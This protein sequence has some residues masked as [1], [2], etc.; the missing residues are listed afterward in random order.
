MRFSV[1]A[2]AMVA[3]VVGFGSTLAIV[4]EAAARLGATPAQTVSWVTVLCLGMAWTSAYLSTRYRMPIVTAWSLA[5]AVLIAAAPAGITM[6]DA[7]GAFI[8]SAVLTLLS[9][10]VPA[11]GSAIARLP[12]AVAGAMLAGLL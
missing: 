11:R 7:I 8:F 5:G 4:V 1:V 12:A 10:A 3:V 6:A 9:G 2:S